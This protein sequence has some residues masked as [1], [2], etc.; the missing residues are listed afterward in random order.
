[1]DKKD[2]NTKGGLHQ[3]SLTIQIQELNLF[4]A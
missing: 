3:L 1:M 4:C 2:L